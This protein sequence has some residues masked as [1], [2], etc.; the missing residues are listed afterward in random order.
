MSSVLPTPVGPE[1]MK[2]AIGRLGFFNPTRALRIALETALTASSWPIRRWWRVSSM[3]SSFT[4]S[5][6]VSF[7]TGTP[8][9]AATI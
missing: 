6:S 8:V 1:K 5:L 9:Q 4:D 3:L 2:L 7:C